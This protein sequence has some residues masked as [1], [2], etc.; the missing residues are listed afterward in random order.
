MLECLVALLLEHTIQLRCSPCSCGLAS[1]TKR[2]QV[3]EI[4]GEV[5]ERGDVARSDDLGGCAPQ[6]HSDLA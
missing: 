5:W 2:K 3:V 1:A 6:R 4:L